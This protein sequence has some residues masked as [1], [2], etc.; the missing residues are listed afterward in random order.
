MVQWE[1]PKLY[2]VA[3][4][5]EPENMSKYC[6]VKAKGAFKDLAE[7]LDVKYFAVSYNNTYKPKSKSSANK[8]EYH[9][10]VEILNNVGKTKIFHTIYEIKGIKYKESLLITEK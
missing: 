6:T 2:G 9:E 4:K 3:L 10:I 7:N 1:K 8:I 5:P